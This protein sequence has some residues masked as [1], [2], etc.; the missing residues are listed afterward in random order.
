MVY[1]IHF[2]VEDLA[3]TRVERPVPLLELSAAMRTLQSRSHPVRFGAWRRS[4]F[5]ALR[6]EAR[7]VLD[8]VPPGG[9]A[10]T[11]LTTAAAG[12]P[13]ELLERVRS[14]PRSRVRADLAHVAE[15]QAP[16]SWARHLAED[17]ELLRRL[18]DGLD[19]VCDVLLSPYWRYL[20][21]AAADDR[22]VRMRQV[23]T[24]GVEALLTTVDPRRVR[25][26]PPVLEFRM[27]SGYDGDLHLG[28]RGMLLVP[29]LFADG[30]AIDVDAEPQPVLRY[31]LGHS[32]HCSS[33]ALFVPPVRRP[34][35]RDHRSPVDSL[36]GRT[37]AAV[38]RTI[39]EHPGCTTKEL[40]ARS[41]TAPPSASEHATVLRTA[42]LIRTVRHRNT[43]L[44]SPTPLGTA[45]LEQSGPAAGPAGY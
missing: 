25:W 26:N 10:P 44:H 31:P 4:A 33:T 45:L 36:L 20:A 27:V 3:R 40:A 14:T 30:P 5:A 11:F 6:P 37:R 43:A 18:C 8:L 12:S 9:W 42:G 34:P 1:R 32:Q 16:P 19:H 38:L 15:R 22:A 39:A 7:M 2:T 24:G 28:G 17:G 35:A 41:G 13:E 21:A 23:L 29:S